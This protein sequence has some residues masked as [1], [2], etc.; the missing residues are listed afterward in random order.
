VSPPPLANR[1]TPGCSGRWA[2]WALRFWTGISYY[3][4][5]YSHSSNLSLYSIDDIHGH[6]RDNLHVPAP[7]DYSRQRGARYFTEHTHADRCPDQLHRRHRARARSIRSRRLHH[8][9]R[10]YFRLHR[11]QGGLHHGAPVGVRRVLGLDARSLFGPGPLHRPDLALREARARGLRAH[12]HPHADFRHDD[13][14][15]AGESGVSDRE[16]Q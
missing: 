14:L 10:E 11:W 3:G 8:D 13:E 4:A 6:G 12:H 9:L 7:R 16:M 5:L 1:Y 15:R 2:I